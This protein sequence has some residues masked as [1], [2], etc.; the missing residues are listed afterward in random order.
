LPFRLFCIKWIGIKGDFRMQTTQ[1]TVTH[2]NNCRQ[3]AQQLIQQTQQSNHQYQQMLQNE[4]QNLQM[5]DQMVQRERMA[6]QTIQQSLQGHEI[7]MQRCQEIIGE[8]N[9][10]EQELSGQVGMLGFQSVNPSFQTPMFQ[11]N[12]QSGQYRQQ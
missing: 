5:L 1:H 10:I 4:Q 9:R 2:V 11:S 7:A 6:V 3:T 8:C 12:L